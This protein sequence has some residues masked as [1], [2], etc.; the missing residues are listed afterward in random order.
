MRLHQ[1]HQ[2]HERFAAHDAV[3]VAHDEVTIAAAPGVEKIAHVAALAGV[4]VQASAIINFA[5]RIKFT[6]QIAPT[7][8]LLHPL[9]RIGGIAQNEKIEAVKL[10]GLFQRFVSRSQPLI[11][12]HHVFVV[13]GKDNRRADAVNWLLAIIFFL[14]DAAA[15]AEHPQ[16]KAIDAMHATDRCE[17]EQDDEQHKQHRARR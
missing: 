4:V 16:E 8:F 5:E 15:R 11:N 10:A 9:V 17:Q 14:C 1:F 12:A 7:A 3:G 2:I 6:R 13:D